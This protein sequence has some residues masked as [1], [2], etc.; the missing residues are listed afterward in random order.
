LENVLREI[1][2]QAATRRRQWRARVVSG[3]A[4]ATRRY[5]SGALSFFGRPQPISLHYD[6]DS[7]KSHHASF[8]AHAAELSGDIRNFAD[9]TPVT[10]ISEVVVENSMEP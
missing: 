10:Q 6:T 4:W 8:D 9:Q 1:A 7:L 3:P 5:L 2:A